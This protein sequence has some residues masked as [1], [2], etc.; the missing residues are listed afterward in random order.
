MNPETNL[1]H[2]RDYAKSIEI[3]IRTPYGKLRRRS[4]LP[5]QY[6]FSFRKFWHQCVNNL[7]LGWRFPLIQWP[8]YQKQVS[9]KGRVITFHW[10][11]GC[12]CLSLSLMLAFSTQALICNHYGLF[13]FLQFLCD[14]MSLV[15]ME[16]ICMVRFTHH[17]SA[18]NGR[19]FFANSIQ[20]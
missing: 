13:C 18:F 4:V 19:F 11:C 12:Y 6:K 1:I 20:P 8:L 2:S 16:Q 9:R 17:P 15:K 7:L 5:N 3:K 10:Y 14:S